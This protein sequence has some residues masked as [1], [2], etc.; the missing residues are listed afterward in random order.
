MASDNS[1]KLWLHREQLD[2][3]KELIQTNEVSVHKETFTEE[4]SIKVPVTREELVIEKKSLNSNSADSSTKP[5]EV[6]RIPISEERIEIVKNRVVLEDISVYSQQI[7]SIKHIEETLKREELKINST[8]R[9][10]IVEKNS[11]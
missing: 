11:Q 8:G 6:I 1:S 9:C 5:V 4:K 3:V 2:I 7:Q 10:D